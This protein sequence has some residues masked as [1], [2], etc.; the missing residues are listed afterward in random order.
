MNINEKFIDKNISELCK[1][2]DIIKGWNTNLCRAATD[3]IDGLKQVARRLMYIM[4][5]KDQGKNYRKVAAITGDTIARIHMHSQS[6]VYT[7]LVGLAQYWNNNIPLIDGYGNYGSV[8][9]DPAGADRYIQAR[10]SEYAYDCFFSDWKEAAVD[11]VLGADGETKEPL[12]LPAKYPN[13]LL[14]GSL[15]IG[16]GMATNIPCFNFKE[17]VEAT[18]SLINDPEQNICLIPD[19]PSGCDIIANNFLKITNSGLG[20]YMMRCTYTINPEKNEVIITSLPYQVTVNTIREKIADA[21]EQGGLPELVSMDDHSGFKVDLRLIIRN[22][23]NPYKFMKKLISEIPGLEKS[24]PV[25]VTVSNDYQSFDLSIKELLLAWIKYRKEQKRVVVS[26]KRTQLMAEQKINDIKI[27]IMTGNNLDDTIKIFKESRNKKE[28]EHRLV[29][30]YRNTEIKMDSLQAQALS[31]MRMYELSKEAYEKYLTKREELIKEI[32]KI[33]HI[34]NEED[35]I[36]KL[37]IGE[38][39]EGIKKYGKPRKSN[40][41]AK[42]ISID[43]EIDGYCILQISSNGSV[44]RKTATN[45]DEEP[46]PTDNNGFAVKVDNDSGFIAIDDKGYH[47]FIKVKEIPIDIELPLNRYTHRS[48]STIVGILPYNDFSRCCLLISKL[49]IVKKI[50]IE[51]FKVSKYPCINI[52]DNDRLIRGLCLKI[53]SN[54]DILIYTK[55]GYGQRMNP[56]D[57]KATSLNAKGSEGFKLNGD[58]ITGCFAICPKQNQYLLY[59]TNRAKVRLNLIKYLPIRNS[60]FDKMVKLI[61]LSNR[62]SLAGIFGCNKLDKATLYF[63]NGSSETID[64]DSIEESTMSSEPIKILSKQ[65]NSP[66][67]KV[68]II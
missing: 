1:N 48:L 36:S 54:K 35:G 61:P 3:Y 68:N 31:E 39:N 32:N 22:N 42:E 49:G 21:K 67:T 18:I 7:C 38:L 47:S 14:N 56:N 27:F 43:S 65:I 10:L 59:V 19:S 20:N 34:L 62:D 40:V 33:E 24:Y 46:I 37:I 29:E 11:M 41:V 5:L 25:N 23:S 57:I 28:I 13:V 50:K 45:V 44:L 4:Y 17:V 66:V 55:N 9:G 60:K 52:S 16:Y 58:E 63:Q 26:H 2:Y 53:E 12:Y 64:I 15:G 6:S 30:K 51:N 8:A